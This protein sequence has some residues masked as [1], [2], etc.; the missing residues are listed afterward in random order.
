MRAGEPTLDE[1]GERRV[2]VVDDT[3]EGAW[4]YGCALFVCVFVGE[5]NGNES[6]GKDFGI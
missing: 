5:R 6:D 2:F 4:L 1:S 3:M